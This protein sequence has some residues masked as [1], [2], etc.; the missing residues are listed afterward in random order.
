MTM[1]IASADA[2][3][4]PAPSRLRS[5]LV[6]GAL[7]VGSVVAAFFYA[8]N[9]YSGASQS[10]IA[11]G[12]RN[13]QRFEAFYRDAA[14]TKIDTLRLAADLVVANPDIIGAFAREDR[15][16]LMA[17]ALPLYNDLLKPRYGFT[18]FNFWTPP[19][20]LFLRSI[21]PKEF[22]TDGS[23]A[24]PS[25]VT[26]IERRQPVLGMETALGGRLVIRAIAPVIEG[27]RLVGVV[28]TGDDVFNLLQRA[29]EATRVEWTSG[30]DRRRSDEVER[31]ADPKTDVV[32]G[33]DV[34]YRFSSDA[35]A[36]LVRA[37]SFQPRAT[38]GQLVV[39]GGRTVYV[40]PFSI[41]NFAGSPTA[42]VATLFDLTAEFA[43]ARTNAAIRGAILFLLL[44]VG[45]MVG[46][47]QFGRIQ[48]SLIKQGFF[49]NLVAAV[50]EPLQAV[51]GHLQN[52]VPAV[53]TA[54]KGSPA[55]T[56]P[57]AR[58]I[59]ERLAFALHETNR[60]AR[61][62][63]EYRQIELFRQ[64]LVKSVPETALVQDIVA[65]VLDKD[66]AGLR[67][68]PHLT[69]T[70]KLPGDL[71]PVRAN[72]NLLRWAIAGLVAYAARG[73]G[74]GTIA[75]AASVDPSGWMR[76]S[77]AGTA[78]AAAGA[79][80][81]ALLEDSRQ[82][83]VRLAG[84]QQIADTNGTMMALVLARMIAEHYG[85]RVDIASGDPGQPGFV[86]SLPAAG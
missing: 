44:A 63:A 37:L 76:L 66:F 46:L 43:L 64:R 18:Q 53:E 75:I 84:P 31:V 39:Q 40:K 78:F 54:L 24:R 62:V 60:L 28:E 9:E 83:L 59:S 12:E 82:F 65:T 47:G 38:T 7:V 52:A 80:T 85:G 79:P 45:S 1:V 33:D 51:S 10:L 6:N 81:E 15:E 22:G 49:T 56:A 71:P 50:T 23:R 61:Y 14:A 5:W 72:A 70:A 3:A 58:S 68:Q 34:F 26:A 35:T 19:A 74:A 11:M 27:T 29:R 42:V 4:S 2:G 16:A 30:L 67:H 8:V 48:Q 21:D 17:R 25:I 73:A 57:M 55:V 32:Q 69:V 86:L 77:I 41:T 20:R 13:A 36:A